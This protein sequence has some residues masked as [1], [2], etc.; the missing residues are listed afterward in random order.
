MVHTVQKWL[1]GQSVVQMGHKSRLE[2]LE[3]WGGGERRGEVK[4]LSGWEEWGWRGQLCG[5]GRRPKS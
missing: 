5:R 4:G 3:G 2:E 1:R